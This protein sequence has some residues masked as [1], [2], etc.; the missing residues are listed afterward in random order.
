M[1]GDAELWDSP[2]QPPEFGNACASP[3]IPPQ[4]F[5]MERMMT[6]YFPDDSNRASNDSGA[7]GWSELAGV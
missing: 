6:I 7:H 1:L 3:E 2:F 4:F 5:P